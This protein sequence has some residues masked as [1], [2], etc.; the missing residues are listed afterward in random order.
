[1][2]EHCRLGEV[3]REPPRR[4][5]RRRPSV[6]PRSPSPVKNRRPRSSP[7]VSGFKDGRSAEQPTA[8]PSP[9]KKLAELKAALESLKAAQAPEAVL[10][11]LAE[12][13]AKAEAAVRG[14]K[15]IGQRVDA[16]RAAL[17]RTE[18]RA[19]AS[20]AALVAAQERHAKSEQE[21]E[22]KSR[23]LLDLESEF[24]LS[25]GAP[26]GKVEELVNAVKAAL[27]SPGQEYNIAALR[28][29]YA[30]YLEER[31]QPAT[32]EAL[33][34]AAAPTA[35]PAA[36]AAVAAKR[37]AGEEEAG[38]TAASP[39]APPGCLAMELFRG[40]TGVSLE[41]GADGSPEKK[42]GKKDKASPGAW[43]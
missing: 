40:G 39:S 13:V 29:A 23:E 24:A 8:I 35:G 22:L 9:D 17:R 31:A 27:S 10:K 4:R 28:T 12:E 26:L 7:P 32:Q 25:K 11:P 20:A 15:P 5:R 6:G 37:P 43:S 21:R 33:L 1:M 36:A 18:A 42:K 30:R 3:P 34:Q 38:T 19:Q 16:A 2:Q 14:S 41:Q